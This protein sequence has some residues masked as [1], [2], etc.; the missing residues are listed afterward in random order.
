MTAKKKRTTPEPAKPFV[1]KKVAIVHDWLLGGGA[2]KVV[3]ELHRM[4]PDAPIYTSYCTREWRQRL[5]GKVKTGI[6][7]HWP[8]SR[9][10]KFIPVFRVW[11][12]SRLDLSAY[13]VVIS[14]SG[15][16]A[17]GVNVP[18][19]TLHINY[20]HAP[21]HYYWS[22]YDSYM[23]NPGFGPLN[24]LARLGLRT[25]VRP[26]REW[27]YRAAQKPHYIIA[28]STHTK[29]AVEKYY[30]RKAEVIFPPVAID[31]F[32]PDPAAE[33][34]GFVIAGRQTPYKRFDLAI[35]AC[36]L[37]KA[38]LKVIGN[39]PDHDRLCAMAGPSVRFLTHVS[40]QEM[41]FHF[42]HA[43]GFIFPGIDDFGIVAV[44]AMATGTP[45][46][47]YRGGGALDYISEGKS[48]VFFD[49]P[50][51]AELA[52]T[53]KSF[54]PDAFDQKQIARYAKKFS[55]DRFHKTLARQLL[56]YAQKHKQ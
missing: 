56:T 55:A 12:F 19:G 52:K 53:L 8:F 30:N 50:D 47:A 26:L 10:R 14:S 45:V 27:D 6:L 38:P 11:W 18:E 43:A 9:M 17:K 48:G 4:F 40:D 34:F 33:R 31:R 39:G 28:N 25:L 20:C 35:E 15:Q 37:A 3:Y 7:Q 22:R 2:E 16:E 29:Q 51:A 54:K 13:D 5:D 23:E 49:T 24:P 32:S 21:T 36:N 42:Q 44:E 46:I 1:G 41:L